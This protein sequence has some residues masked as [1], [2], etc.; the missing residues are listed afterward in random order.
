MGAIR[1]F[2]DRNALSQEVNR[3]RRGQ[4]T[5]EEARDFAVLV[6]VLSE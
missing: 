1:A 6:E 2:L 3:E 4:L 5:V